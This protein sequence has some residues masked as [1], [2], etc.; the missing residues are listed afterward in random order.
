[1][2][3]VNVLEIE[4]LTTHTFVLKT[5]RP[6][7]PIRA[8]QCFNIGLPNHSINREYS[9]CSEAEANYIEFIIREVEDGV[10][11]PKLARVTAGDKVELFGPYGDFCIDKTIEKKC[12]NYVFIASGTGIAPFT[13][14]VKSFPSINYT[15]IHGIRNED[16]TYKSYEFKAG[17]Y[18]P[19]ISQPLNGSK[20]VRVTDYIKQNGIKKESIV[21]LCGNRNMIAEAFDL[22]REAGVSGNDIYTEVFF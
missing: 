11:S 12:R 5:E 22:C 14:F 2:G 7:R 13:S 10:I 3:Q 6:N 8:G 19:C 18:I 17:S 20:P 1:M 9:M 21:F 15:V 16:E 4:E